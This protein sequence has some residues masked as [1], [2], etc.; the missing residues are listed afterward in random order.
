[1]MAI[2]ACHCHRYRYCDSN[3]SQQGNHN[4][5]SFGSLVFTDRLDL[6]RLFRRRRDGAVLE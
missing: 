4:K 6:G 3:D 1:M 5:N 2:A